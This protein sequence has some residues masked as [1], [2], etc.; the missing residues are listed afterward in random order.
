M[1]RCRVGFLFGAQRSY[2]ENE[3]KLSIHPVETQPRRNPCV[4]PGCGWRAAGAPTNAIT[5]SFESS[6]D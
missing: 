3:P 6:E 4:S 2:L 1:R 5:R